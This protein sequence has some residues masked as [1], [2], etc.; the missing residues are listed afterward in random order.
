MAKYSIILPVRNGGHYV[1]LC[2]NSVLAQTYH[3]FNFIVLD[4]N[5]TDD[6]KEWISSLNDSRVIIYPSSSSLTIEE[7]WARILG[8][9]KNEFITIIGH[10]DILNANYLT[11]IN[12]LINSF[13]DAGLYQTHFNFINGKGDII[14]PC[15]PMK[16]LIKPED[17]FEEVLRNTIEII[18]TGFMLR[19]KDYDSNGGIPPYPN[20]LYADI[21]IWIKVIQDSYMVVSPHNCF[22]FRFH[23]DNTSKSSGEFRLRAF[24][25][26]I[27]FFK[28]LIDQNPLYLK[29][30][31]QFGYDFMKNYVIGSCHKLIYI[32]KTNRNG[33]TMDSII[34]TAEKSAQ[35]VLPG[36]D[37]K[38]NTF[39]EI[40]LAQKIDSIPILRSI[41]LFFKSFKKRTF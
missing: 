18:G 30:M 40:L 36:I 29:S 7:N 33:V 35:L 19:S 21:E 10:D 27:T 37:F 39:F 20:L 3:D 8:I 22:S 32:P 5:S 9:D 13:P 41:F 14:R 23:I 17:F 1:K 24:E 6:T 26:M 38:P 34:T 12:D 31:N 15:I 25:R 16:Q 11:V 4:N 2:V 28:Q